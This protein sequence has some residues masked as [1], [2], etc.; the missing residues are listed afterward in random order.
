M[1]RKLKENYIKVGLDI[2][3]NKIEHLTTKNKTTDYLK[4]EKKYIT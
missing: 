4:V 1:V 2:N 3:C